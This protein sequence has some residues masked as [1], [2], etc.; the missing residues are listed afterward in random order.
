MKWLVIK[1]CCVYHTMQRVGLSLCCTCILLFGIVP[2]LFAE[3]ETT[4]EVKE[5]QADNVYVK[6]KK[7][8]RKKTWEKIVDFPGMLIYFPLEL[9][10][11]LIKESITFV[12]ESRVIPKTHDLLT[13]DD[14]RRGVLPTYAPRTGGGIKAFQKGWLSHES[15]LTL[16]LTAGSSERQW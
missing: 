1:M 6:K 2:P 8:G 14:G 4:A 5:Q 15:K 7:L 3:S 13:S 12:S 9:T 11:K 10:F 16:A